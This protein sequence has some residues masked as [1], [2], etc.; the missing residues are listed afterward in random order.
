MSRANPFFSI[1]IP[2]FNREELI[3]TTLKSVLSQTFN[4]FEVIVIDDGGTDNTK[5]VVLNIQS[6]FIRYFK[7]ENGERGAA[8]NFGIANANGKYISFLDSDDVLYPLHFETAYSFLTKHADVF[9]YAQSYEVKEASSG[10]ILV[11]ASFVSSKL[12][13][14]EILRGNLLSCFGVFIRKEVF[15]SIRF[16]EDRRFA[17]TEDWLLWLQLAARYPFYYNNQVTGAMLE[18]QSRSVLSFKEQSLVYRT[19]FLKR[20]LIN[21]PVFLSAFGKAAVQ[22]IYAHMLTYTSLHLAM[23]REKS[24]AVHFWRKAL[25]AD[26]SEV[27]TKRSLAILKKVLFI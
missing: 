18:H 9:C 4:D 14:N 16:E 8:R 24:R 15:T 13:N 22:K 19:E 5:E 6:P 2:T 21:D 27:L 11:P 17:G 26:F 25:K 12:V 3:G 1:I 20:K 7:K 23:S 10:K